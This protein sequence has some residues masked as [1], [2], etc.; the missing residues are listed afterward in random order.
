MS[1]D[2][3]TYRY[4]QAREEAERRYDEQIRSDEINS[5]GPKTRIQ[6]LRWRKAM[7]LPVHPEDEVLL[8]GDGP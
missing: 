1:I 3:A 6:E 2:P 5:R 7:G 4:D 8:R